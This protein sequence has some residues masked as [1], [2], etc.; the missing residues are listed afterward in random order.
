MVEA[1]DLFQIVVSN[2]DPFTNHHLFEKS[3]REHDGGVVPAAGYTLCLDGRYI[4]DVEKPHVP[5]PQGMNV[6]ST[7]PPRHRKHTR[8]AR[9]RFCAWMHRR[10]FRA[11]LSVDLSATKMSV[12]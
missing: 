7:R 9:A 10:A 12:T 11:R 5:G 3:I 1:G 4:T 8:R 6:H 2:V